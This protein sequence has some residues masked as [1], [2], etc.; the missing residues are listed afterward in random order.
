MALIHVGAA[1]IIEAG[2]EEIYAVLTDYRVGHPA[3][4]PKPY[5]TGLV[6]EQGGQ[7]AGTVMWVH[8]RVYGRE[9]HY[10]QIVSE[11][12]PG[13]VL[14][15]A[16]L[17]GGVTTTFKVEPLEGGRQSRVTITTDARP[18]PGFAGLMERLM[19]PAIAGRIYK[20]EL[21]NLADYLRRR[22]GQPDN[23]QPYRD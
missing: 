5:F 23:E 12:E 11:P 17:D 19:Q 2:P 7:G 4:L 22:R 14:V 21:R 10:H 20:Q 18:S 9:S 8:M 3:I 15:E 13:R 6:I 1:R 16:N